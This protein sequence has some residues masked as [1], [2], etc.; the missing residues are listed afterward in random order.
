MS[1]DPVL[2]AERVHLETARRCLVGMQRRAS[3]IADYGVDE[4]AS[5]SLGR[6]R[7]QRLRALAADPDAP[8]FFGRTDRDADIVAG[9]GA[10]TFHIGRRHVRDDNGDPVVIDWR[11]P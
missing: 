3:A 11:A 6:L 8:P 10:E 1:D 7:A 5:Q 4:L 9:T 2:T